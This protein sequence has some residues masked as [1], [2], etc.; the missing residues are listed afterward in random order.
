MAQGAG[1]SQTPLAAGGAAGHAWPVRAATLPSPADPVRWAR[2]LAIAQALLL[3]VF[4]AGTHGWLVRGVRPTTTDFVSFYAAGALADRGTPALAY[5]PA[6]HHAAEQA[7]AGPGIDYEYFF[8]PPPFLL[9]CALLA[10]LP[11]LLAFLLFELGTG[12]AW[13]WACGRIAGGGSAARWCLL[14]ARPVWWTLGIGQNSFLSAALMAGG[15]ALV[16]RRP[17]LAGACFGGLVFK[18]HLA[19][20]VPVALIAGRCWRALAAAALTAGGLVALSVA[21]FGIETWTAFLARERAAAATL[22]GAAVRLAAHVEPRG[23]AA[24]LGAPGWLAASLAIVAAVVA[25]AAVAVVWRRGDPAA[26]GAALAAG[27]L[28][29]APFLLFYDLMLG[30]VAAAWLARGQRADEAPWLAALLA[31]GIVA[32]P[33]AL[34]THVPVGAAIGPGLLWLAWRRR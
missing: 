18:P 11:Y 1:R 27:A 23:A 14:A 7:A 8:Y 33:L 21:L 13:L 24:L 34:S 17:A 26:R 31:A 9:M 4:V 10:R 29:A 16:A 3:A 15:T 5:A 30:T 12:G 25:A 2:R 32:Y 22:G 20:L 19:L 28:I 6:A